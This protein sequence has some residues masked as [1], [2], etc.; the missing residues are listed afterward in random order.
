MPQ[1]IKIQNPDQL[2]SFNVPEIGEI[3]RDPG[4]IGTAYVM[5]EQGYKRIGSLD[6]PQFSESDFLKGGKLGSAAP[7]LK[8]QW[9][10]INQL[11]G[12]IDLKRLPRY[13]LGDIRTA[14]GKEEGGIISS[15]EELTPYISKFGA[16]TG[17]PT[18][19]LPTTWNLGYGPGV[20]PPG[21]FQPGPQ[22]TPAAGLP[23]TQQLAATGYTGQQPQTLPQQTLGAPA[24]PITPTAQTYT[25][26]AGDTLSA[27]AARYGV[28]INQITGYKSGN[29]NLIY[30][31]EV[32]TI[33]GGQAGQVGQI[34]TRQYIQDPT[35]PNASIP[36]PNYGKTIPTTIPAPIKPITQPGGVGEGITPTPT[37]IPMPTPEITPP[38]KE[39]PTSEDLFKKYG[40]YDLVEK[41]FNRPEKT[42]SEIYNQALQNAGIIDVI[43]KLQTKS[44]EI[45]VVQDKLNKDIAIINE[46][47]W[48]SENLRL[49]S[50]AKKQE[51]A[52]RQ[53]SRLTSEYNRIQTTLDQVKDLAQDTANR[54]FNEIKYQQELDQEKL[55]FYTKQIDEAL[56]AE[57]KQREIIRGEK[58]SSFKEWEFAGGEKGTG[59]TYAD[60]LR[61]KEVPITPTAIP[62]IPGATI[63]PD[64]LSPIARMVYDGTYKLSD[65]TPTQK[66]QI[67]GELQ[68]VG[69]TYA[70][71][72]EDKNTIAYIANEMK[73][74]MSA[75][76]AVP[77]E[78]KGYLQGIAGKYI[79]KYTNP[80]VR[81]FE[82]AKGIVGMALTRLFEKGRISDED[83]IFYLSLMPDLRTQDKATAQAGA[84]ELIR[85]LNEKMQSQLT[86]LQTGIINSTSIDKDYLKSLGY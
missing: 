22:P 77:N 66:A 34:D 71:A 20:L 70:M 23:A 50:I 17:Q 45:S 57:A 60:W 76:K 73:N 48:I 44:D 37:P 32:L 43:T 47:P 79:G 9:Q 18:V 55:N 30:P 33:G 8:T 29:P 5:T 26:K 82:A 2:L 41:A 49:S 63:T 81:K 56:A 68:A 35:N 11:A 24:A 13:N 58:P 7:E 67:A 86:E 62:I 36:N 6:L 3:F 64:Q 78:W 53:L 59:M 84:D 74:V 51:Y 25:V 75:W 4:G 19:Q 16:F 42:Y 83:R 72:N 40:I 39:I 12:Q 28:N 27:I 38:T 65:I 10:N 52:D 15:F 80:E 1:T 61:R 54:A 21:G 14:L 69:Y 85:L 31:G 46:D